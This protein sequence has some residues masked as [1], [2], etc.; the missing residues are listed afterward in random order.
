MSVGVDSVK[1]IENFFVDAEYLEAV[2]TDIKTLSDKTYEFAVN[3]MFHAQEGLLE[4]AA[5]QEP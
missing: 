5:S 2:A 4:L 3:R 1:K